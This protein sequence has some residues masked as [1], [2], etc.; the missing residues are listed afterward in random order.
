MARLDRPVMISGDRLSAQ[1]LA[2]AFA[3][4]IINPVLGS[5]AGD[6]HVPFAAGMQTIEPLS[7]IVEQGIP[8]SWTDGTGDR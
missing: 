1:R 5:E 4:V 8:G 7:W 3:T 6:P 2:M